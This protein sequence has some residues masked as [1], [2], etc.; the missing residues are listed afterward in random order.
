MWELRGKRKENKKDKKR[1]QRLK[2]CK[3]GNKDGKNSNINRKFNKWLIL[4]IFRNEKHNKNQDI[5]L[6][7]KKKL[8]KTRY[9][10]GNHVGR[11]KKIKK[12]KKRDQRLKICK[13][14]DNESVHYAF[15]RRFRVGGRGGSTLATRVVFLPSFF[16]HLVFFFKF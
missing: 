7:L 3:W 10:C 16:F 12:I 5:R 2:I 13:W 1:D 9:D 11:E 6:K 4:K 8:G 14:G 15:R